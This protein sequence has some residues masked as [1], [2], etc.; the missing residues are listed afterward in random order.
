M[1]ALTSKLCLALWVFL[2]STGSGWSADKESSWHPAYG[3]FDCANAPAD[4]YT[5]SLS[6]PFISNRT[7]RD[8]TEIQGHKSK[9]FYRIMSE[10]FHNDPDSNDSYKIMFAGHKIEICFHYHTIPDAIIISDQMPVSIKSAAIKNRR[11]SRDKTKDDLIF[12]T[13]LSQVNCGSPCAYGIAQTF[14]VSPIK[15][16]AKRFY[17]TEVFCEEHCKEYGVA[18]FPPPKFLGRLSGKE[19]ES[20]KLTRP[21]S[22]V[23]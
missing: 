1:K 11:R 3:V 7:G 21:N 12:I 10:R 14:S 19:V 6:L 5:G 2:G 17:S 16:S 13:I 8:D 15:P 20:Y 23:D 22:F 9:A 18:L 4:L